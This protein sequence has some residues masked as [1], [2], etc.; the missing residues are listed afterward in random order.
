MDLQNHKQLSD[1]AMS[2]YLKQLKYNIQTLIF[3]NRI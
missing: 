1:A 2:T 3:L